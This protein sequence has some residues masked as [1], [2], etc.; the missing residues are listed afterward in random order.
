MQ[1]TNFKRF[2]WT[3][4]CKCETVNKQF[5]NI[6]KNHNWCSNLVGFEFQVKNFRYFWMSNIFIL[7]HSSPPKPQ[8]KTVSPI[9]K[10]LIPIKIIFLPFGDLISLHN[11][12]KHWVCFGLIKLHGKRLKRF[13]VKK[14]KNLCKINFCEIMV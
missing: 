11:F 1:I 10:A 9:S 5:S 12:T 7:H 6:F 2:A 3:N 14:L 8:H 13:H 4:S